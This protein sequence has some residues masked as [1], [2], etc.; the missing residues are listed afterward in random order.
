LERAAG[1]HDFATGFE[2][3]LECI[4]AV[5]FDQ[6]LLMWGLPATQGHIATQKTCILGPIIR[7]EFVVSEISDYVV[8]DDC[9]LK[10]LSPQTAIITIAFR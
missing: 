2:A 1:D 9:G 8:D 4:A 6:A 5:R 7:E 3:N 10:A